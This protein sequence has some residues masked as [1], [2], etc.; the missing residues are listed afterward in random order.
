MRILSAP[1]PCLHLVLLVFLDFSHS[2]RCISCFNLQFLHNIW[3]SHMLVTICISSLVRICLFSS[4]ARF[5]IE[6]FVFLLLR[7]LCIYW[8]QVLSAVF[9]KYFLS[10]CGLS[11]HSLSSVF[12][13]GKIFN[14]NEAP[15]NHFFPFMCHAFGLC[16]FGVVS[17]N[18]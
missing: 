18:T 3:S 13:K 11:F 9:C 15:L 5:L 14:F 4:F 10:V 6:V 8:I 17:K 7:V 1:H 16:A 2:N 12:H